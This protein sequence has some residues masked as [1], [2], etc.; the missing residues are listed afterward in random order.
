M[1]VLYIG[2]ANRKSYLSK[3]STGSRMIRSSG[4]RKDPG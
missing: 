2:Y 1:T 4:F 3:T